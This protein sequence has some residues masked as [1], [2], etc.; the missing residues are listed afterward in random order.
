MRDSGLVTRTPV[1]KPDYMI[2]SK[3][4]SGSKEKNLLIARWLGRRGLG[5]KDWASDDNMALKLLP[6]LVKRK[7]IPTL[8][9]DVNLNLWK[10]HIAPKPFEGHDRLIIIRTGATLS[11]SIVNAVLELPEVKQIQE[12]VKDKFKHEIEQIVNNAN[13]EGVHI[14]A[15]EVK[16]ITCICKK[17]PYKVIKLDK[18]HNCAEC[19]LP[20]N[21]YPKENLYEIKT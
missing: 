11:Q 16:E 7:Y 3:N 10:M 21:L 5:I 8:Q 13:A 18:N 9:F 2:T 4:N 15:L 6:E 12:K 20:L 14:P 17:W 19:G 1:T